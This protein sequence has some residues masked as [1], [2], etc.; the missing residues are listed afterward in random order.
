MTETGGSVETAGK[1]TD[2][3]DLV[4][5]PMRR[6]ADTERH[7]LQAAALRRRQL[8]AA[9]L[10]GSS[11]SW[12]QRL[13]LWPAAIVGGVVVAIIIAAIAV[14]SAFQQEQDR[15]EQEE[16]ERRQQLGSLSVISTEPIDAYLS[17]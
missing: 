15:K 4:P 6:T 13:S 3:R 11:R 16:L 12:R 1:E 7:I 17:L 5:T 2:E 8:R 10:Y 9:L 14:T